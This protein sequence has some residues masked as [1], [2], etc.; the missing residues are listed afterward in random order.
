MVL[1]SFHHVPVVLFS[2]GVEF[3]AHWLLVFVGSA[4]L[5]SISSPSSISRRA[6]ARVNNTVSSRSAMLTRVRWMTIWSFSLSLSNPG[7]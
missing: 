2:P 1:V 5:R 3:Y 6:W 4:R 7:R